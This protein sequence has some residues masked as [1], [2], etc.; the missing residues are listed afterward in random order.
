MTVS[1]TEEVLAHYRKSFLYY[2]DETWA[3]EGSGFYVGTLRLSM[4]SSFPASKQMNATMT[5]MPFGDGGMIRVAAGICMDINPYKFTAPWQAYEF[6]QQVIT[7]H[8]ELVVLSMAWLSHALALAPEQIEGDF[9]R[10]PDLETLSYWTERFQP[11]V[12]GDEDVVV[13]CANRC[14]R[15]GDVIYAGTSTVLLLGKG[16]IRLWEVL[17]R[18][19][20]GCLVVD[21]GQA[22]C[23]ELQMVRRST[24]DGSTQ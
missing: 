21:T 22:P 19:E 20:E 6:A 12:D 24:D 15:E 23:F 9:A 18:A 17:G 11:V 4:A 13:V 16:R 10:Q 2:T 8:V 7:T 3:S 1:P 14:G 5:P